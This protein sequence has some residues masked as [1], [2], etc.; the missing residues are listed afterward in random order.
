MIAR[1]G[2]VAYDTS[3]E[4]GSWPATDE[5]LASRGGLGC[6]FGQMW[7]S[8]QANMGDFSSEFETVTT[9]NLGGLATEDQ[10]CSI[11]TR[12]YPNSIPCD[13]THVTSWLL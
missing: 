9:G 2:A 3:P 4:A 7:M 5:M 1:G 11:E 6:R 10:V 8:V 13:R 12:I